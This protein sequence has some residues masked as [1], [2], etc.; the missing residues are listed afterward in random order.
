[1]VLV[2]VTARSV[3]AY[4]AMCHFLSAIGPARFRLLLFK[5]APAAFAAFARVRPFFAECGPLHFSGNGGCNRL[6][7]GIELE[8]DRL[9][10]GTA[11]EGVRR[12]S[13]D[14]RSLLLQGG[15]GKN[16]LLFQARQ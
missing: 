12:C 16:R 11:L 14:R 3:T 6:I 15:A 7:G 9:C 8:G 2:V 4:E 13:I 5:L 1:M 10:F